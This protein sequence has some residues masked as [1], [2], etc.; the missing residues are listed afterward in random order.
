MGASNMN[1]IESQINLDD[2]LDFVLDK[3]KYIVSPFKYNPTQFQVYERIDEYHQLCHKK[4]LSNLA[5]DWLK[6]KGYRNITITNSNHFASY[7][8]NNLP[9]C[10]YDQ[11]N[12][13]PIHIY[14]FITNY[15]KPTTEPSQ[16]I[17]VDEYISWYHKLCSDNKLTPM[18]N[19]D[20]LKQVKRYFKGIHTR[21]VHTNS[22]T[23]VYLPFKRS[24]A[25]KCEV[26]SNPVKRLPL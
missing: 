12:I 10:H 21:E 7:V 11:L 20:Y 19:H 8:K 23:T 22:G 3:N 6:T 2:F 13:M 25:Y 1:D 14:S 26:N 16:Y 5:F 24:S 15:Y 17:T 18:S 4:A 9:T